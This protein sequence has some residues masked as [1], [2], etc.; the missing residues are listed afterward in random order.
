LSTVVYCATHGA[1]N[2]LTLAAYLL[3]A[4]KFWS[5]ISNHAYREDP[6]IAEARYLQ[7]A[8]DV[9]DQVLDPTEFPLFAGEDG[10][11]QTAIYVLATGSFESGGFRADVQWCEDTGGGDSGRSWG[12]FQSKLG[13]VRTADGE[14][15]V[16]F[17]M[18]Q[19]THLAILQIRRS[20]QDCA[21][22]PQEERLAEYA[23]GSC[24]AGRKA[25]TTRVLRAMN[26]WRA[27]AYHEPAIDP[28]AGN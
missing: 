7:I 28:D 22:L 12:L 4:M 17:S 15:G 5:P 10:R 11:A 14:E 6:A 3:G 27:H 16:C 8:T 21:R 19:A 24:D 1:M 25:S 23:S 20:F 2:T 9:A 26:Y 18:R 13:K